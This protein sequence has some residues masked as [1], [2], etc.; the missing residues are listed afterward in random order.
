MRLLIILLIGCIFLGNA[1]IKCVSRLVSMIRSLIEFGKIRKQQYF[2]IRL[3]NMQYNRKDNPR[4]FI[5][6]ILATIVS[7]LACLKVLEWGYGTLLL[8]YFGAMFG[9]SFIYFIQAIFVWKYGDECYLTGDGVVAIDKIRK[10][11][12]RFSIDTENAGTTNEI[13]YVHVYEKK[14]NYPFRYKILEKES[15]VLRMVKMLQ[16]DEF[17]K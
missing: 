9:M 11:K 14:N 4:M 15:E 1:L 10:H 8:T 5:S 7:L 17:G 3:S 6:A 16:A 2:A 12:C 13:K